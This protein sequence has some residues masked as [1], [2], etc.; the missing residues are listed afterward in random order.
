MREGGAGLGGDCA[1]LLGVHGLADLLVLGAALLFKFGEALLIVLDI[2]DGPGGVAAE[3]FRHLVALLLG[4][5]ATLLLHF[6]H[7]VAFP[8]EVSLTLPENE[9]RC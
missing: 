4:L 1:A 9:E 6:S 7:S 5:E 3:S 8:F 2:S